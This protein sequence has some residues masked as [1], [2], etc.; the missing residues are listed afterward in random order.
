MIHEITA[1]NLRQNLGGMLSLVSLKY[2]PIIIHR[3]GKP[4]AVLIDIETFYQK[5][6]GSLPKQSLRDFSE[7]IHIPL[8]TYKFN[9]D[10]A[11]AR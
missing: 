5:V 1:M 7:R 6:T 3:S 11:N 9:R 2:E 8:S 10:D 4:I